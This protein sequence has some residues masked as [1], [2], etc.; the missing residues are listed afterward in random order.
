[1]LL[2]TLLVCFF[3]TLWWM[4]SKRQEKT[5]SPCKTQTEEEVDPTLFL[6]SLLVQSRWNML[7]WKL[8]YHRHLRLP[9]ARS[10][11]PAGS[12]KEAPTRAKARGAAAAAAMAA[13]SRPTNA[14]VPPPRGALV[15]TAAPMQPGIPSG[16]LPPTCPVC[17]MHMVTRRNR[18]NGGSFWGCQQWPMCTGTRRPWDTG[19]AAQPPVP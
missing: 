18:R 10:L 3:A 19:A 5:C 1:M 8:L 12:W 14:D 15:L 6:L 16:A 13:K 11:L 4:A 17:E 9:A 7:A 2:V